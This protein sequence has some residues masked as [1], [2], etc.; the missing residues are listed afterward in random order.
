MTSFQVGLS[1]IDFLFIFID[2]VTM[3]SINFYF[4]G[5]FKKIKK[6]DFSFGIIF[7]KNTC[8]YQDK[9]TNL[10]IPG[11]TIINFGTI[12]KLLVGICL[13]NY[14]KLFS[15]IFIILNLVYCRFGMHFNKKDSLAL[16]GITLNVYYI[17]ETVF[18]VFLALLNFSKK[19]FNSEAFN[20]ILLILLA[21]WILTGVILMFIGF[22]ESRKNEEKIIKNTEENLGLVVPL[23]RKKKKS[24]KSR[25]KMK[26]KKT[27]MRSFGE[28]IQ[29]QKSRRRV[30]NKGKK[31]N[32]KKGDKNNNSSIL[33][34]RGSRGFSSEISIGSV[35]ALKF[36]NRYRKVQIKKT[37]NLINFIK[38]R[39]EKFMKLRHSTVD[40]T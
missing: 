4:L 21:I 18:Q 1:F 26:S 19:L 6:E 34:Q 2:F 14:P 12:I 39:K 33:N 8:I 20:N 23:G 40:Q 9:K 28:G 32:F 15:I 35:E 11:P 22:L 13:Q 30:K 16:T 25:K 38:D 5:F 31:M 27:K 17:I 10:H 29:F 7:V 24:K 36:K 37:K 3:M